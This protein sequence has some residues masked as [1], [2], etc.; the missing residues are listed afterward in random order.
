MRKTCRAT[1]GTKKCGHYCYSRGRCLLGKV[2]ATCE[3]IEQPKPGTK[4]YK[5]FQAVRVFQ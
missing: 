5:R 3:L 2:P 1:K 4:K